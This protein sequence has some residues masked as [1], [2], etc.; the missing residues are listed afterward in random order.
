MKH[1]KYHTENI[2]KNPIEKPQIS[3]TN[4]RKNAR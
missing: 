1:K 2:S 3:T 4:S